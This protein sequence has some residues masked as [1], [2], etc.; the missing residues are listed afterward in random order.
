M[1]IC[2]HNN[3]RIYL[4]T[5]TPIICCKRHHT[6]F[7]KPTDLIKSRL[8][9][10]NVYVILKNKDQNIVLLFLKI[11]SSTILIENIVFRPSSEEQCLV[12]E[13]SAYI[14][15]VKIRYLENVCKNEVFR[16][17]SEMNEV[18]FEKLIEDNFRIHIYFLQMFDHS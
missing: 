4:Y 18:I 2:A 12:Q 1:H 17:Y 14:L 7:K 13:I 9:S 8:Y 15:A 11:I 3:T 6:K 5:L 16:S 10:Q